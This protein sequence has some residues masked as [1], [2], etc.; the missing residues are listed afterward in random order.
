[1]NDVVAEVV[2]RIDGDMEGC[3]VVVFVNEGV[4][5]KVDV[6]VGEINLSS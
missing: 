6:N 2:L 1:M 4:A 5:S 3:A